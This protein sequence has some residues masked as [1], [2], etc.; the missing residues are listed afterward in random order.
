MQLIKDIQFN[1]KP[2]IAIVLLLIASKSYSENDF[3]FDKHFSGTISYSLIN[4]LNLDTNKNENV[5]HSLEFSLRWKDDSIYENLGMVF[6]FSSMFVKADYMYYGDYLPS[7]F[8]R[9]NPEM[10]PLNENYEFVIPVHLKY[11]KS[12]IEELYL[13][14]DLD[15]FSFKIGLQKHFWGQFDLSPILLLLPLN[16]SRYANFKS[17]SDILYPTLTTS[18]SFFPDNEWQLDLIY[19]FNHDRDP[20]GN[21]YYTYAAGDTVRYDKGIDVKVNDMSAIETW[22]RNGYT[23]IPRFGKYKITNTRD[24]QVALRAVYSNS[25]MTIGLTYF[26][27]YYGQLKGVEGR[28]RF[29]VE[30][31]P[32]VPATYQSPGSYVDPSLF[33]P[34]YNVFTDYGS[35]FAKIKAVAFEIAI[36]D[37]EYTFKFD[38]LKILTPIPSSYY[39]LNNRLNFETTRYYLP[40]CANLYDVVQSNNKQLFQGC[41]S[42]QRNEYEYIINKNRGKLDRNVT[43]DYALIGFD[44]LSDLWKATFGIV[45]YQKKISNCTLDVLL[46]YSHCS[47]KR[48]L[49]PFTVASY[50]FG[51]NADHNIG[52]IFNY[53]LNLGV[54]NVGLF[55]NY[56]YLETTTYSIFIGNQTSPISF[57]TNYLPGLPKVE[58]SAKE[59]A[60]YQRDTPSDTEIKSYGSA[61]QNLNK[62]LVTFNILYKY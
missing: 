1:L 28:K 49:F 10:P 32:R 62:Y 37:N 26:V 52:G 31:L 53:D 5:L 13:R 40:S 9:Y 3:Y 59:I 61:I 39:D 57:T 43:Y 33:T 29:A 12:R 50:T 25:N 54:L 27:G 47:N 15:L 58:S 35:G 48:Y 16:L 14:Y 34:L 46:T 17:K 2:P 38:Y 30:A 21:N 60:G 6:E 24:S 51:D 36:P 41:V 56:T 4:G 19:F 55:Y 44:Y 7:S 45:L 18:I 42:D 23:F 22:G 8:N 20:L 11:T